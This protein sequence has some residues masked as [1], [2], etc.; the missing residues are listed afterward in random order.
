MFNPSYNEQP[1]S[2]K[3]IIGLPRCFAFIQPANSLASL[4]AG[5]NPIS[6]THTKKGRASTTKSLP[7]LQASGK[8]PNLWTPPT[9]KPYSDRRWSKFVWH[10]LPRWKA[11]LPESRHPSIGAVEIHV[12]LRAEA[13]GSQA[14]VSSTEQTAEPVRE[15]S[16]HQAEG[17]DE[18]HHLQQRGNVIL[19]RAE[20]CVAS[21]CILR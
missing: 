11:E 19:R 13:T 8:L 12:Q 9:M 18:G 6:S 1:S 15:A 17:L 5:I 10:F 21:T 16:A 20:S 7:K 3:K 4:W 2:G 14:T